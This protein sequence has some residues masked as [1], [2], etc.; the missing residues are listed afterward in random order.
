[1]KKFFTM[2]LMSLA[3]LA[4]SCSKDSPEELIEG[5]WVMESITITE[6]GQT[7]TKTYDGCEKKGAWTFSGGTVTIVS[8]AEERQGDCQCSNPIKGLTVFLGIS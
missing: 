1:M 7:R 4:V 8:C 6:N 2:A 3:V 5:T